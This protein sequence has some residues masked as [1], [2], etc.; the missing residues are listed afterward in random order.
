MNPR[1][2]KPGVTKPGVTK[3][4]VTKQ[5]VPNKGSQQLFDLSDKA[6]QE[7][8]LPSPSTLDSTPCLFRHSQSQIPAYHEYPASGALDPSPLPYV[9]IESVTVSRVRYFTLL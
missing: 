1:V 4:G 8:L 9:F 3:P 2:T 6:A 7:L 5:G